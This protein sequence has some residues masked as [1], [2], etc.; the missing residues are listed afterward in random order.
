MALNGLSYAGGN[1]LLEID[2]TR[3]GFLQ[4]F[5]GGNMI[6]E[7]H[8]HKSG[9]SNF[10]K[11]NVTT[12]K[13]G[14]VKFKT[15]IGMS[16]AVYEWMQAAFDMG[17]LYKSG[18]VT[19]ANFDFK[20]ERR[21]DLMDMLMTKVTMPAFD[22]D[23]KETGYFDIEV[24]PQSVRWLKESGGDL[25]GEQG[26]KQKL[27]HCANFR[28]ELG[29][30]PCTRVNK[31]EGLSWECKTTL[32]AVGEKREYS[33]HPTATSVSDFTL[34]IS[35]ADLDAWANKAK[36]WFIDGNTSENDELTGAIV[37][38]GPD[39][40][41]ELGRIELMNV[42]LKEFIGNP[43]LE[44]RTEKVARFQVKCYAERIKLVLADADS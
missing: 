12:V 34:H 32:D 4:S 10:E 23:S 21:M 20:S 27:F 13:W 3:C 29:G 1:F 18:A 19:V 7:V 14:A 35:M 2:G 24:M 5:E 43:K 9:V 44:A 6:A 41:K 38:L 17:V 28:L 16:K 25:R 40:K 31:I 42:G 39:M 15:G 8:S 37:M 36:S 33:L 30:L 26:T 11:K 22:G